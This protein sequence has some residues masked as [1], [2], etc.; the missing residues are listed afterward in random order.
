MSTIT[1]RRA[2]P[3]IPYRVRARALG[4]AAAAAAALAVWAIAVPGLG[5]DLLIRFGSGGA[6]TVQPG[7]VVGAALA[8]GL[9]GWGLLALLERCTRHARPIWT[10]VAV[11]VTIASLSLPAA[12]AVTAAAAAA[13]ALM[14]LAVA[15]VLIPA[16]RRSAPRQGAAS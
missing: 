2:A 10:A 5:I 7:F 1:W 3:A 11:A 9:C 13:L 8:A 16:L 12:A 4:A 6:Q 15:A 14:H